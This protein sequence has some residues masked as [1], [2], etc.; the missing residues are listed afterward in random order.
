[1]IILSTEVSELVVVSLI[2][3]KYLARELVVA[4]TAV[5]LVV[6]Q[7]GEKP[8][9]TTQITAA[10]RENGRTLVVLWLNNATLGD[11]MYVTDGSSKRILESLRGGCV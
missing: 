10:K 6:T 7:R 5:I 2:R 1:M 3:H 8:C 4:F 11:Y 9:V